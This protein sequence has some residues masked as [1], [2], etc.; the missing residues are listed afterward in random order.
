VVAFLL[1][2]SQFNK[3]YHCKTQRK[4]RLIMRKQNNLKRNYFK[5]FAG[6]SLTIFALTF[7]VW[8]NFA[9]PENHRVSALNP[10]D[11]FASSFWV[12]A[13]QTYDHMT[14]NAYL[15]TGEKLS[16]WTKP[17]SGRPNNGMRTVVLAPNGDTIYD[18]DL[19]INVPTAATCDSGDIVATQAGVYQIK[20][21]ADYPLINAAY[22][23]TWR[24]TVKDTGDNILSGRLFSDEILIDQEGNRTLVPEIIPELTLYAI[25]DAGYEYKLDMTNYQGYGSRLSVDAAGL[26]NAE[27]SCISVYESSGTRSGDQ[28]HWSLGG[29]ECTKFRLFFDEPAADLPATAPSADG[30]MKIKPPL[31]DPN[32]NLV[33]NLTWTPDKSIY[34]KGV[35]TMNIDPN[36]SGNF[37]VQIDTNNDGDFDDATD[38]N[39]QVAAPGDEANENLQIE[40]DGKDGAGNLI[41]ASQ[42]MTARLKF[43]KFAEMHIVFDDVEGLGGFELTMLNGSTADNRTIYWNDTKLNTNL[44]V[45]GSITPILDGTSGVDS[46][47]GVHGWLTAEGNPQSGWGNNRKI[48]NWT[49]I[50]TDN[51]SGLRAEIPA[52]FTVTFEE[53]GG[54]PVDDQGVL[55]NEPADEPSDP[56]REQYGF[57]GWYLLPDLTGAE[58]DFSTPVNEDIVLYA[59]WKEN[60]RCEYDNMIYADD[61]NC[62]VPEKPIK[63]VVP[64]VPDTGVGAV[65]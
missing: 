1:E 35:F 20:R 2:F 58:Y 62:V 12:Q 47:G 60:A 37:V 45:T 17:Y 33:T 28:I 41:P 48:D 46:A 22:H 24:D 10:S 19:P 30:E 63:P 43:D 4:R 55:P 29:D 9:Q 61:E 27:G 65:L 34:Q 14:I 3:K 25:N 31:L 39:F 53:N 49:Y 18:C 8:L 15:E 23:Y 7:G 54:S 32:A 16:T 26:V 13:G 51:V 11:G 5:V 50:A 40:F 38:R 6:A 44:A 59:C 57:C 42:T 52:R 36:F 56:T 64:I 21:T